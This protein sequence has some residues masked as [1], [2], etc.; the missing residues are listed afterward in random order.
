MEVVADTKGFCKE[1]SSIDVAFEMKEEQII[2]RQTKEQLLKSVNQLLNNEE[3]YSLEFV[4]IYLDDD[5]S[6]PLLSILPVKSDPFYVDQALLHA[7]VTIS[8]AS[9]FEFTY[10]TPN[11][12]KIGE[13]L[14][15]IKSDISFQLPSLLNRLLSHELISCTGFSWYDSRLGTLFQ[16]LRKSDIDWCLIEKFNGSIVYRSRACNYVY[17]R[18]PGEQSHTFFENQCNDCQMY[19]RELDK[20]YMS[21]KILEIPN[22]NLETDKLN[23]SFAGIN[24]AP[25]EEE[26]LI[27]I[28][29]DAR[30]RRGRPKGSKNKNYTSIFEDHADSIEGKEENDE[31]DPMVAVDIV[32]AGERV[33]V[34]SDDPDFIYGNEDIALEEE[35]GLNNG[36]MMTVGGVP[37][38]SKISLQKGLR[39]RITTK[40]QKAILETKRKRGRP[41]IK[42]GPIDCSDCNKIFDNVKDYRKH[43]L[44]HI[45]SFACSF[46]DC[47]KR[48]KSQK[49]LDIHLRKHR[50]EK[51]YVCSDCDKAYAIRQDL[52]LHIRT[53]H[54]GSRPYKCEMCPKAFARAHQLAV[55]APVHTGEK[56]HLCSECG[57]SFSSVS[58]LIDHRKRRHLDI[59]N[60]KCETCPKAFFTKQELEAHI[61]TH[62]GE[63]PFSCP[64]CGKNFS[65]THHLKR[66]IAG[67]H[68]REK[69]KPTKMYIRDDD[70]NVDYATDTVL[71]ITDGMGEPVPIKSVDYM[72]DE[73]SGHF[74]VQQAETGNSR[75]HGH[76]V[77]V[78]GSTSGAQASIRTTGSLSKENLQPQFAATSLLQLSQVG[79]KVG[80]Q[81]GAEE[82]EFVIHPDSVIQ[83]AGEQEEGYVIVNL[84]N[85]EQRMMPISQLS[86]LINSEQGGHP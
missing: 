7:N 71:F 59:R 26:S 45:N 81:V 63:K 51:P 17:E 32:M 24:T 58:S 73:E 47:V 61:R 57:N 74:V 82:Q 77:Q 21:G 69:A 30:K 14:V 56:A 18:N 2:S 13:T 20:K 39:K 6:E 5:S 42:V 60:K 66:H 1:E 40:R 83:V 9:D 46:G 25:G 35:M 37:D 49:D 31:N 68:N 44:E 79:G 41:P 15:I 76:H 19:L 36:D 65:R 10:L 33:L 12:E 50:G 70:D 4:T 43:C 27:G 78:A 64:S 11:R 16:R 62:T 75:I 3:T 8:D 28:V 54:T 86:Q 67:V 29:G 22:L 72:G 85:N 48:F 80:N 34:K 52:R 84:E 55:H 23:E 53:Q 38:F